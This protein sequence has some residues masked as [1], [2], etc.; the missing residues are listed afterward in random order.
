MLGRTVSHYRISEKLDRGGMGVVYRAEDTRL[1]RLVALKFLPEEL[2]KDRQ[3]MERMRREARS[4]S[5]LN[6]PHIC[7]IYDFDEHEGQ[8]FIAMELLEGQTLRQLLAGGA[9][10]TERLLDLGIQIADALDAAHAKAILH[11]DIKPANIFVTERGDAKILD[12]GLAKLVPRGKRALADAAASALPTDIA[13]EHLTSPGVALGT[14]AYM[15]PEQARGEEL[16]ARADLFSFGAVLYEMATSRQAFPGNTAAVIHDAILNRDPVPPT[17]WNPAL[18]PDVERVIA[19]ALEKDREMRYQTAAELRADLRRAK[20]DS[21]SGRTAAALGPA[22]PRIARGRRLLLPAAVAVALVALVITGLW[23]FRSR[24]ASTP[25]RSEWAQLTHFTDSVTS[26]ALSPDGRML[27]FVHGPDTFVGPG[28]IYVKLLPGGEPVKLTDDALEKMSPVFSPDGSRIAYTATPWDTWVVPVLGGKPRLWLPNASGLTWIHDERIL[29]S[30]VK[31][32]IHMALVT[33][34]ESRAE[35]RDLYVPPPPSGMAHRSYLSPDRKWVLAAEMDATSWLPCR[36]LPFDGSG[37]GKPVGPLGGRC[38]SAAWSPD[39]RWMYFTVDTGGGFHIWRQ[40]FPDG[41]PEQVTSGATQE[42]G[43]AMAPDGRSFITSIGIVESSIWIHD[44]RGERQVSAEGYASFGIGSPRSYFSADGKKL[45]YLMRRESA[46]EFDDGQLWA[47]ELDSGRTERLLPGFTMRSFDISADGKRVAF[48][49][50][51]RGGKRRLW[52]ASLDRRFPPRRIP[53]PLDLAEHRPIFG[54]AGDLFFIGFDGKTN[55]PYRMKEDGSGRQRV[56]PDAIE[57]SL[58]LQSV[59]PD[60]EWIAVRWFA[61]AGEEAGGNLPVAAFPVRGGPSV[62]ICEGCRGVKWS[63]DGRFLYLPFQGMGTL[64]EFGK[65]FALPIR[66]GKPLPDL[67]A[68]G[69]RS[70]AEAATLPGVR[71]IEHGNIS[72]A[73]ILRSTPMPRSARTATSTACRCRKPGGP[74]AAG[75]ASLLVRQGFSSRLE[76]ALGARQDRA[77]EDAVET[78]RRECRADA[79]DRGIEERKDGLLQLRNDFPPEPA[80][81]LVLVG[82]QGPARFPD[83]ANHR[84]EIERDEGTQVDHV[85]RLPLGREDLRRLEGKMHGGPVCDDRQVRSLTAQAGL[86]EGDG[87]LRGDVRARHRVVVEKLRLEEESDA[88]RA[89][90]RA[91][92]TGGVVR[93]GGVHD[94]EAGERGEPPLDVLRVVQAAADVP[95]GGEPDRHVRDE[96]PIRAPVLV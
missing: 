42:E 60:G 15:A 55:R 61:A 51:D 3:A 48:T 47:A 59:S 82:D 17:R 5:T 77:L 80:V 58:P 2:S 38:T 69:V 26:P 93:E 27:A 94:P 92:Q 37:S 1:G 91:Q 28:Q 19:K 75:S 49:A 24:R 30:E 45:Y 33:A 39:G 8:P 31:R 87:E 40:R 7:T 66:P 41:T 62:K 34:S 13:E 53:S 43:I 68:S 6:H 76:H 32:G 10:P 70:E 35:S 67:P 21:E 23:L 79:S 72:P 95:A 25:A 11:R 29:F 12:F 52:L 74:Q 14:V 81:H 54:P 84:F 22:P 50:L 57:G 4:A 16:D 46:R 71:V 64:K 85:G 96:L 9:L 78:H 36:L 83:G 73:A 20:R 56:V 90:G 18:P 88:A 44:E 86:A 63:A 89:D 65:T